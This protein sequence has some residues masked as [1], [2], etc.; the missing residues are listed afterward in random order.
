MQ[1]Q[2]YI[3]LAHKYMSQKISDSSVFIILENILVKAAVLILGQDEK[4]SD[5]QQYRLR[6]NRLFSQCCLALG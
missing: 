3:S 4:W 5:S 1:S 6:V 2:N